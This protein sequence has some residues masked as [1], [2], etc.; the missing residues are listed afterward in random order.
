[1]T[2][3]LYK[4]LLQAKGW[5]RCRL[6]DELETTL[7]NGMALINVLA[8]DRIDHGDQGGTKDRDGGRR[9]GKKP[10]KN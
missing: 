1:M 3:S 4:S 5:F 8:Q 7:S 9:R 6:E 2:L 10:A